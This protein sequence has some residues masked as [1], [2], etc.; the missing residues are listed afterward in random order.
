MVFLE[1]LEVCIFLDCLLLK[2]LCLIETW[3]NFYWGGRRVSQGW[4]KHFSFGQAKYSAGYMH[5]CRGCEAADICKKFWCQSSRLGT[6]HAL[7]RGLAWEILALGSLRVHLLA[8]H[9]SA[10]IN[11][12]CSQMSI[13]AHQCTGFMLSSLNCFLLI[14]SLHLTNY[15]FN[16]FFTLVSLIAGACLSWSLPSITEQQV[17]PHRLPQ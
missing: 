15:V 7:I 17:C 2:V 13:K 11:W 6:K 16:V 10:Q 14:C 9:I 1:L 3:A 4:Q 5:L 12:V 8:I